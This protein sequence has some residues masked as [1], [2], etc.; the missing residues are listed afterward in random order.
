MNFNSDQSTPQ[1]GRRRGTTRKKNDT[2]LN[3][4][5]ILVLVALCLAIFSMGL[6]LGN[7][8]IGS[9]NPNETTPSSSNNQ[10]QT[11]QQHKNAQLSPLLAATS[12]ISTSDIQKLIQESAKAEAFEE[13]DHQLEAEAIKRG[14]KKL[15]AHLRGVLAP[16]DKNYN[17]H[18]HVDDAIGDD[19]GGNFGGS[20]GENGG[21]DGGIYAGENPYEDSPQ[22]EE[23]ER[24][25]LSSHNRFTERLKETLAREKESQHQIVE[26]MHHQFE[27]AL[28]REKEVMSSIKSGVKNIISHG[29]LRGD[30]SN[31]GSDTLNAQK[32][33]S[34]ETG[35]DYYPYMVAPVPENY[36][37]KSYEPLGGDRFAEYKD[38]ES[39]YKITQQLRDQSDE[40]AR[41]RRYHVLN[42]MK[43][44]W[45][46]YK[47]YAFGHDELHPISKRATS[48]WG[49]MGT[50]LVDSLDTLWLMG[51]KDEFWEGRD[52]VRDHL[53]NDRVGD[54]SQFETT[55]RSLGGLLSAYDLSHDAVFLKKAE[56]L[57]SRLFKSF[58]SPNGLPHGSVNLQT[59]N[60]RNFGWNNNNYIL[61]EIGTNQLEYRYLARATGN[62]EYAK[63][64]EHAFD[65][66]EQIMPEDG[67]MPLNLKDKGG[68]VVF[69]N[70]HLSFGAMGDSTYEY[71]IKM[72]VQGGRKEKRYRDM[73]DKSIDGMHEKLLQKSIPNGLTYIADSKK[74]RIDH[75]MDHLVCFMGGALALGA[76]TDPDGPN[77]PRAQRDLKT[78]KALTYT[79]YQMYA[80]TKTGISPEYVAFDNENDFHVPPNAAFY[81][82]RPET[83]EAFYYLNKLTGDP[84]YRE[85]GWEVFQSIE[86]YCKVQY[87][88]GS[89]KNVDNPN[90]TPDD[91]MES[92]FLAETMKYL[93]LLFDPDSEIDILNKH[94]FNT[95]AHP[96]KIF[97]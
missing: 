70:D 29:K 63:K 50:T 13:K 58:R 32:Y 61:A 14:D 20:G 39:P 86:K 62:D 15:A 81:I 40:L 38:G 28:K 30:D 3:Q 60:S 79:C 4:K 53:S 42:A 10:P 82:L 23:T 77:S 16:G 12:K 43:H 74:G 33:P 69:A 89:L 87:G 97:E 7:H 65:I 47:Q 19:G 26:S 35:S 46:N 44:V 80:R 57:G 88:Y 91:R 48:N 24:K 8:V 83:V 5:S 17:P 18:H 73:W 90:M 21:G 34:F 72:W 66:L 71:M 67:L 11:Q 59:G 27:E 96:F 68:E 54:V 49:G 31:G 85:W 78:A 45:K 64:S 52:W 37:F 92:F 6:I 84:I 56:D 55:I 93:Y 2:A 51:M 36:D 95:E 9:P 76:Y 41:S 22:N 25:E 94:V 1:L 75:K